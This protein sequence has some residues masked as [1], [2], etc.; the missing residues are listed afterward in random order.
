M[1]G[2]VE[3]SLRQLAIDLIDLGAL[4]RTLTTT[5]HA[6]V[7]RLVALVTARGF[8]RDRDLVRLAEDYLVAP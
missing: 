6:E 2:A 3:A 4:R 5:D 1:T 7:R 8:H